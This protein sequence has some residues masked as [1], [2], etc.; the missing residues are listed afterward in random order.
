M[1]VS[2]NIGTCHVR[3]LIG[4]Q[5]LSCRNC[6]YTR[7]LWL[8][9]KIKLELLKFLSLALTLLFPVLCSVFSILC[10]ARLWAVAVSPQ[11]HLNPLLGFFFH[12]KTFACLQCF[13]GCHCL[14]RMPCVAPNPANTQVLLSCKA[15]KVL[16]WNHP[17]ASSWSKGAWN[18]S[19]YSSLS[20]ISINGRI[21]QKW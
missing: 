12:A 4:H 17:C 20:L 1:C 15:A 10:I 9:V 14:M 19:G 13:L 16:S 8:L 2:V 21:S 7:L 6:G 5:N 11:Q 18:W 3:A